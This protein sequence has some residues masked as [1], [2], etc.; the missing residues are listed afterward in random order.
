MTTPNQT[1]DALL[2]ELSSAIICR[3]DPDSAI[4]DIRNHVCALRARI[5]VLRTDLI[6]EAHA[7]WSAEQKVEELNNR[8]AALETDA[9]INNTRE[10]NTAIEHAARTIES[11]IESRPNASDALINLEASKCAMAIRA[12]A[13]HR[14]AALETVTDALKTEGLTDVV[15]TFNHP[16]FGIECTAVIDDSYAACVINQP[17]GATAIANA[18]TAALAARAEGR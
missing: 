15:L 5:V 4:A 11:R 8:I 6:A 13:D 2:Y 16:E 9:K 12:Y 10:W 3:E 14:I 17:N 7:R 18:I 1:L